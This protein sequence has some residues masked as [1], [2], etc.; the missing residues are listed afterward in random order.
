MPDTMLLI[1]HQG[2]LGDFILTFPAITRLKRYYKRID[3]LCQSG[4]GKLA[5]ALGLVENHYS[6]EAAYIASLFTE[7]IDP[8]VKAWLISYTKIILFA[9]SSQ[10]EQS[11]N[12]ISVYPCCR[13]APKP[14]VEEIGHTAKFILD[15][16]VRCGLIKQADTNLDDIW[17]PGDSGRQQKS[18]KIWLHPGAGS[19]RKRWALSNFLDVEAAL[20]KHGLKPQF[21][22][23]PAEEDLADELQRLGRSVHLVDDLVDLLVLLK[24]AGGYIGNDSGPS[25]LAAFLGLPSAVIF[26]PADPERWTPVGRSV[27]IVRPELQCRP[28]FEI[29]NINCGDPKCLEGT[30]PHRVIKAFY[31]VYSDQP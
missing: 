6:S 31:R 19:I 9:L 25:H 20:K 21:I 26:G 22:L 2:A 7:R 29:D 28:C 8:Q 30:P 5:K 4:L 14:P 1:I 27:V 12:K 24:S 17:Y 18:D 3:V 16:L 23:G 11:V 10:L 15:N 13:I